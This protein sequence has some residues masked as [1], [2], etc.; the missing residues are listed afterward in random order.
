MGYPTPFIGR[1]SLVDPVLRSFEK[2]NIWSRGRFG[3]WKYE[4]ANQDHSFAQGYECA[5][6]LL[7]G[8]GPEYEPT[9]HQPSLVNGRRN[10]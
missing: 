1:D 2:K 5:E 9:L 8:G 10:Q 6:R 3:A 4:V 7:N